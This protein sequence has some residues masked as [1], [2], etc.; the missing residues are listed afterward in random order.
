MSGP[1]LP[2]CA[3]TSVHHP[4]RP[5]HFSTRPASTPRLRR[6]YPFILK[7]HNGLRLTRRAAAA[8]PLRDN[9]P[10][11][12]EPPPFSPRVSAVGCSRVLCRLLRLCTTPL[13]RLP[14]SVNDA[15]PSRCSLPPQCAVS[16]HPRS[17]LSLPRLVSDP[18]A[19]STLHPSKSNAPPPRRRSSAQPTST[20]VILSPRRVVPTCGDAPSR[21]LAPHRATQPPIPT[22][23]PSAPRR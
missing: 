13:N 2:T 15:T 11:M 8:Y 3:Q 1:S 22:R 23:F 5:L 9:S 10:T 16:R 12:R 19:P 14:C 20:L 7:R 4:R 21:P 17:H 6:T 18:T